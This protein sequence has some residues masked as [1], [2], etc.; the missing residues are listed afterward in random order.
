MIHC[1]HNVKLTREY[2]SDQITLSNSFIIFTLAIPITFKTL[3]SPSVES[4]R[5][6]CT[7]GT[8]KNNAIAT[9]NPKDPTDRKGSENP[10]MLYSADPSAGPK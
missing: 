10:P 1:Y 4:L 9:T 5:V 2:T 7:S 3:R 8:T 6:D